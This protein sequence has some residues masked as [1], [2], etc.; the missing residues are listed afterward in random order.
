MSWQDIAALQH[1]GMDIDSHTMTHPHLN[2]LSQADLDY[3]IGQSKQCLIDH[4]INA[5]IFAYPDSDGSNNSTVV[6][7]VAKYYN[8]ARTDSK[9]PLAFLHCGGSSGG[10]NLSIEQAVEHQPLQTGTLL[11]AGVTGILT[12]T[13]H[14]FMAYALLVFAATTT[15]PKCLRSSLQTLTVRIITTL[16]E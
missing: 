15:I 8:L 16:G 13:F 1:D 7:T 5:T 6:N 4:R 10:K 9:F 12:V 14:I 11:T 3:E 2:E